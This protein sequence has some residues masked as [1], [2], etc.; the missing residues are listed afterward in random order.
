VTDLNVAD[1]SE[2]AQLSLSLRMRANP[3]HVNNILLE[4]SRSEQARKREC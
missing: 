4:D 2:R 3:S 1:Y